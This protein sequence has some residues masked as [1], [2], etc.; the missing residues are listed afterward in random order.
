MPTNTGYLSSSAIDQIFTSGPYSGAFVTSSF[1][2][3]NTLSGP[4]IDYKQ[5]F[6]SDTLD[7]ISP[8]T[9]LPI[10][11]RISYNPITCPPG[12][13]AIPIL[14]SVALSS[15]CTATY[16]YKYNIT[17]NSASSTALYTKIQYS[18]TSDFS[19]NTATSSYI[20]NSSPFI[21]PININNLP[22]SLKY[23]CLPGWLSSKT[24]YNN[25]PDNLEVIDVW[26]YSEIIDKIHKYPKK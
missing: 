12:G 5:Y 26:K 14:T 18:T 1:S 11:S 15:S 6:I 23:L 25:L 9:S 22:S 20:D 7:L 2:S 16:D 3:G 17:Y 10:Y 21:S 4:T 24:D 19:S 13:C 8:C